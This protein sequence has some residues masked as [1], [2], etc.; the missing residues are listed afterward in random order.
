MSLAIHYGWQG[1]VP[2][3][4]HAFRKLEQSASD[5]N[6]PNPMLQHMLSAKPTVAAA[7]FCLSFPTSIAPTAV[8]TSIAPTAAINP[9]Y[10]I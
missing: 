7:T 8:P 4:V 9:E 5:R 2:G 3:N 6:V 10:L 1:D